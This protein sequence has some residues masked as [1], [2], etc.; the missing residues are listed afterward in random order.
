MGSGCGS[1]GRAVASNSRGPLFESSDRQKFMLN[2]YC[3]PYWKDKNKENEAGNGPFFKN[4][5]NIVTD[6]YTHVRSIT[7]GPHQPFFDFESWAN[8][9]CVLQITDAIKQLWHYF[10]QNKF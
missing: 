7:L 3:Q 8:M 10:W 9:I 5:T 2:I 4:I 1:V 6:V